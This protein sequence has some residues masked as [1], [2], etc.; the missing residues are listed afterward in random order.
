M[1]AR[2]V[3]EHRRR[4]GPVC[5]RCDGP[6]VPGVFA[7]RLSADHVVPLSEGGDLF[8][9]MEVACVSC[10]ARRNVERNPHLARR[11]R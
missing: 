5:P 1:A 4:H 8:G 7:T 6:E 10:N 3:A 2:L 11:G 9:A